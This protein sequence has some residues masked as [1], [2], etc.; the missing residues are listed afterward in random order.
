MMVLAP[1]NNHKQTVFCFPQE[2]M[3]L[4]DKNSGLGL[5]DLMKFEFWIL[6]SGGAQDEVESSAKVQH[7][8]QRRS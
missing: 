6:V 8:T 2:A 7:E 4:H 5:E 1:Q 3:I